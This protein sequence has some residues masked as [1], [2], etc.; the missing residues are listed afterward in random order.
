VSA[1]EAV[2]AN[3]SDVEYEGEPSVLIVSDLPF[4]GDSADPLR[5]DERCDPPG[6]RRQRLEGGLH[7]RRLP[8]LR[9][10]DRGDRRVGRGDLSPKRHRLRRELRRIGEVGSYKSGCAAEVIPILSQAPGGGVA[11]FWAGNTLV[12]LTETASTC[13]PDG[14]DVYYPSGT[15]NYARVVPMTRA[16]APGSPASPTTR[17]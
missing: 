11:I 4:Q 13:K 12:C 15:C 10:L 17:G 8:G 16:R 5:A 1:V 7:E 9:W 3:C 2:D 6:A 14:P